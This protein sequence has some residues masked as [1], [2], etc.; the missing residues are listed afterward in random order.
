MFSVP[1][2]LILISSVLNIIGSKKTK[3]QN[4]LKM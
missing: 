1:S 4:K 3:T 2:I